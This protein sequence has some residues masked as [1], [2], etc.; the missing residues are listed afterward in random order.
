MAQKPADVVD[1]CRDQALSHM[2][3][4]LAGMLA[5]LET[6]FLE[7]ARKSSD[8]ATQNFYMDASSQAR[9]KSAAMQDAFRQRFIECFDGKVRAGAGSASTRP[10]RLARALAGGR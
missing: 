2:A 3:Q 5:R 7:T 4:A 9:Q 1:G 10:W 6:D 8:T